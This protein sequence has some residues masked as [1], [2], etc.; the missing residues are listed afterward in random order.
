[1]WKIAGALALA[2][3]LRT[4][5]AFKFFRV[6]VGWI[7]FPHCIDEVSQL[8]GLPLATIFRI[9]EENWNFFDV[10]L[11]AYPQ[12]TSCRNA[13]SFHI[14][15]RHHEAFLEDEIRSRDLY[16]AYRN[17]ATRAL[18]SAITKLKSMQK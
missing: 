5:M 1:V 3:F 17:S 18:K 7:P 4:F 6:G 11:S 2:P 16:I 10:D 15:M 9:L 13:L 8:T 12:P 14:H